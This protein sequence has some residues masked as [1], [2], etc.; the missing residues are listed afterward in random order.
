ML[1]DT[2]ASSV[3]EFI[4]E[5]EFAAKAGETAKGVLASKSRAS[6]RDTPTC[7]VC[8]MPMSGSVGQI[9]EAV[10][11]SLAGQFGKAEDENVL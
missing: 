7:A 8:G 1:V 3:V 5:D 10:V 2:S 11:I 4:H 9:E 6:P